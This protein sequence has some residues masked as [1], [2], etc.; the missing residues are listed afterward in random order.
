MTGI[1]MGVRLVEEKEPCPLGKSPSDKAQAL[2]A[3]G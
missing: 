1:E 2:L 3:A